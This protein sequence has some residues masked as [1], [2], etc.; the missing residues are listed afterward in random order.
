MQNNPNV[1]ALHLNGENV[2]R[3][4]NA[5]LFPRKKNEWVWGCVT[6]RLQEENSG[7]GEKEQYLFSNYTVD[8]VD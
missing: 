7:G 8:V 3:M 1:Y 6:F 2:Y 5:E 4:R